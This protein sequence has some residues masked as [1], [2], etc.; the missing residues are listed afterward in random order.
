MSLGLALQWIVVAVLLA[1]SL[2]LLWQRVIRPAL[3]RPKAGC[4]D[5]GCNGCEPKK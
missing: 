3:Q 5:T 4:A 2:R 1:L